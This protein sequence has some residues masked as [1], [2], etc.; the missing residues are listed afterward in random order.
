[1]KRRKVTDY[2]D[3]SPQKRSDTEF[4]SKNIMIK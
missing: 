4:E 2:W 1:M 3:Y